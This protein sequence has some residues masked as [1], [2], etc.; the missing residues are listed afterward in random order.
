MAGDIDADGRN[1]RS[2]DVQASSPLRLTFGGSGFLAPDLL[3]VAGAERVMQSG[4]GRVFENDPES[5]V[6]RD[7]WRVGGGLEW[8]GLGSG[9]R[10][11]P[12]RLGA[13][14]SQ[15]PYHASDESAA[16]EWSVTG[17]VGFRLAGD[18][19]DPL[20]VL[21]GTLERGNRSGFESTAN[22]AGLEER[23]WRFTISL[24]LFGR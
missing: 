15:L 3:L 9:S 22:P 7:T 5:S 20:A 16:K 6:A 2:P 24:S 11:W 8:G 14:W 13:S 4:S 12:I 21:D 10:S 1:D 19:S 18:P 23:Y 17:G